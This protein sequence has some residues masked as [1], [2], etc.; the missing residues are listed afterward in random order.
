MTF[1]LYQDLFK[2]SDEI[3]LKD[4]E[5]DELIKKI[6]R[7]DDMGHELIYALIRNYQLEHSSSFD[8]PYE[9]KMLKLG[10]KFDLDKLPSKLQKIVWNFTDKHLEKMKEDAK[11]NKSRK[12]S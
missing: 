3:D 7:M 1:P 6:K 9:S 8:L 11:L 5:K 4:E 10:L 12:T 2:I